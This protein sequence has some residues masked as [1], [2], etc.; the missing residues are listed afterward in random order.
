MS[1]LYVSIGGSRTPP[2]TIATPSTQLVRPFSVYKSRP[3]RT[4]YTFTLVTR[5]RSAAIVNFP[6]YAY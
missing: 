3:D 1:I 4:S 2:L 5:T 6:W